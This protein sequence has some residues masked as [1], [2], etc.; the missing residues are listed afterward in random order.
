MALV[1]WVVPQHCLPDLR[2]IYA[3]FLK[4]GAD[5]RQNSAIYVLCGVLFDTSRH[6]KLFIY[7]D[8]IRIRAANINTKLIHY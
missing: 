1:H 5:S 8:G 2:R 6:M 7:Q 3:G 4:N